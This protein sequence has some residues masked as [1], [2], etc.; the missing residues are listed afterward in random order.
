M[1]NNDEIKIQCL[2]MTKLIHKKGVA[3]ETSTTGGQLNCNCRIMSKVLANRLKK[4]LPSILSLNQRGGLENLKTADM[5][6]NIKDAI[7]HAGSRKEK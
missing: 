3:M 7:I 1:I 5:L 4:V 2:R 6:S